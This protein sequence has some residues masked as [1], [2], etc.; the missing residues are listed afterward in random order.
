MYR[1][2]GCFLRADDGQSG[3]GPRQAGQKSAWEVWS[4][5]NAARRAISANPVSGPCSWFLVR[6]AVS[7]Q[8]SHRRAK[9]VNFAEADFWP[10]DARSSTSE[11]AVTHPESL[12]VCG[13]IY[14]H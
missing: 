1:A 5:F 14:E 4:S 2:P 7:R 6:R 13:V 12:I 8:K 9:R 10:P 11:L 3:G